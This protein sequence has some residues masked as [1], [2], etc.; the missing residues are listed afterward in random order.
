MAEKFSYYITEKG[1]VV[2]YDI[3]IVNGSSQDTV[4]ELIKSKHSDIGETFK[5][6]TTP[7][8]GQFL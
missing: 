4:L 7:G 8:Q 1:N 6:I 2:P 5:W 3:M